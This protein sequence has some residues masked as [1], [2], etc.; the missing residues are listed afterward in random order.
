MASLLATGHAIPFG[1]LR[2]Q[3]YLNDNS[4]L[5]CWLCYGLE[6]LGQAPEAGFP[7]EFARRFW[8]R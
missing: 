8:V 7:S 1:L 5:G 6:P 3:I 4:S 2:S